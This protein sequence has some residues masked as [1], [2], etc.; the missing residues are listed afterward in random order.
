ME[1]FSIVE[2]SSSPVRGMSAGSNGD[3]TS[4][5]EACRRRALFSGYL[6]RIYEWFRRAGYVLTRRGINGI[7]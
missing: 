7:Q 3:I 4:C 6:F 5:G 1:A 2:P